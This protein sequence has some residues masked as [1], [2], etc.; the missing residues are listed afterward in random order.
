M[1]NLIL[2]TVLL[3]SQAASAEYAPQVFRAVKHE[4]GASGVRFS[5]PYTM[6]VHKGV[7]QQLTAIAVL[8]ENDELVSARFEIP[9]AGLKTGN[10]TRDCHMR[11]S[12]GIDYSHSAFP[13]KHVCSS[14]NLIPA[15][16]PDAV[17]HD[18][19]V[20]DFKRYEKAHAVPLQVGV[21]Q[22][23]LVSGTLKIHGVRREVN[24]LP[25]KLEMVR[26]ETGAKVIKLASLFPLS[27]Q[28]FGIIVKPLKVAFVS[29][30]VGDSVTVD[31]NL[32]MAAK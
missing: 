25:L 4:D 15:T 3:L 9:I 10:D 24:A 26:T 12:L 18:K 30:G 16:G 21:V 14:A 23:V 27:L 5:I 6:G 13:S 31:L 8:N 19:I 32:L 29:V 7:A 20:F 11:E 22:E 28:S 2:M 1:R 17:V